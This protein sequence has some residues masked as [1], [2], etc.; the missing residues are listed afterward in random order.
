MREFTT[1]T[2]TN[3]TGLTE[4]EELY[5]TY[6]RML[7]PDWNEK[8][9][10]AEVENVFKAYGLLE[11]QQRRREFKAK[12]LQRIEFISRDSDFLE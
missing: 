10:Q 5:V 2:N 4:L 1:T 11:S 8:R 6:L 12:L 3:G 9:I 7:C